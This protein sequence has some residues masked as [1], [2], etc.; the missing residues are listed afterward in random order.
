MF[1]LRDFPDTERKDLI[2]WSLWSR[3]RKSAPQAVVSHDTALTIHE[4]SDMMPA[5]VHLT[6][7]PGFLK[8]MPPG[9]RFHKAALASEKVESRTGYRVTRP[10]CTFDVAIVKPESSKIHL[11]KN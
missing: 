7:P 11:Q 5:R 1:R 10:L 6:V 3:D 9:C 4:L 2:R 8:K